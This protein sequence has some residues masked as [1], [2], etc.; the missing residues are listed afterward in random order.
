[1][2]PSMLIALW[3]LGNVLVVGVY[4]VYAIFHLSQEETVSYWMQSWFRQLPVLAVAVG[5]VIGHLAWPLAVRVPKEGG[6][7]P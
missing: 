5:I 2:Y 3:L 6:Q 4:D 7:G 1:L